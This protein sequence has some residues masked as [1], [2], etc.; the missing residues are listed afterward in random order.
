[1][2]IEARERA[3]G[4]EQPATAGQFSPRSIPFAALASGGTLVAVVR[5][6]TSHR[7][8]MF[9]ITPD[10]PGQL[11]IARFVGGAAR[12]NMFDRSTWR[13]GYGTLIAPIHWLTDDPVL[14]F[15]L[16]L[17][18]NAALGG[19]SCVLL[20]LLARRLTSLTWRGCVMAGVLVALAPAVLFS[21]NWVWSEALVSATC[22][23]TLLVALA[24]FD[25]PT[26]W[27]GLVMVLLAAAGFS[28]H[29]RL[30][31]LAAVTAGLVVVALVQRR[32]S[33]VQAA[34]VV[35]TGAL[36]LWAVARYS[37]W[38][39]DRIWE[40]PTT[41][42]TADGVLDRVTQPGPVVVS[43]AGQVWYQLVAT[44]GVAGL[45]AIVLIG[46][47]IGRRDR[48]G[49][50]E[51]D[52]LLSAATARIVLVA[53]GALV[54]LA[55]VFMSDR[56]RPDQVVY[57]RYNDA[58][59]GPLVI[60]GIGAL[61]TASA[62]LLTRSLLAVA[63][64]I[65]A[66]AVVLRVWRNEAL[67]AD[68]VVRAMVLGLAPYR[69]EITIDVVAISRLALIV[70]VVIGAVALIARRLDRRWAVLAVL[71]P[72]LAVAWVRSR[73]VLDRSVNSWAL[74]EGTADRLREAL[75]AGQPV[76]FR[77][78][79]NDEDPA[80]TWG[81]QRLRTMTYQF[82]LPDNAMTEDGPE[83]GPGYVF[84][85]LADPDLLA[86]GGVVRWRDP[87]VRIGLWFVPS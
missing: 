15:N 32:L 52:R 53:I 14:F 22:L 68:G 29:S 79:T 12:W 64:A 25:C 47:A 55:V 66:T 4:A 76:R 44:V 45:G 9:H 56:Y 39:V 71:L 16:A 87:R 43:L 62:R 31:P 59:V 83:V 20:C 46:R 50:A 42:N 30:A 69:G 18:V 74:A 35:A 5:W 24:F 34:V 61:T 65:V 85:P 70:L 78:V 49:G 75:P 27:R 77:V 17:V 38:L 8:E 6:W 84:A 48:T 7:R 81:D 63:F 41:T 57:G 28:A 3:T 73:E 67:A 86:A 23:G 40:A 33:I 13:P 72:L 2:D 54:A 19:L 1:M 58:V 51:A 11:A 82:Y 60:V 21:T 80:A 36:S 10:E 37:A 26:I